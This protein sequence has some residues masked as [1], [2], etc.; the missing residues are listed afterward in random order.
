MSQHNRN[1]KPAHQQSYPTEIPVA[2][3]PACH[4]Y[5]T[6]YSNNQAQGNRAPF[7]YKPKPIHNF[8]VHS[9]QTQYP[10]GKAIVPP[11]E[12]PPTIDSAHVSKPLQTIPSVVPLSSVPPKV[13]TIPS[14]PNLTSTQSVSHSASTRG[15]ASL[16][17]PTVP[18]HRRRGF[19]MPSREGRHSK[20][21]FKRIQHRT[22]G[23]YPKAPVA[24]MS[25]DEV[26]AALQSQSAPKSDS[27][28]VIQEC[29]PT[30]DTEISQDVSR[31]N[32]KQS[33]T[34]TANLQPS[35]PAVNTA[36]TRDIP[37]GGAI[38]VNSGLAD[39]ISVAK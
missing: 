38:A 24:Q 8:T 13:L 20:N 16:L 35:T 19:L 18:I 22:S 9:I 37:S 31:R 32:A 6:G 29:T 2:D 36:I 27:W 21:N 15:L 11:N 14:N 39:L 1:T 17:R 26:E 3:D 12:F 5:A 23:R 33:H 25:T 34:C 4:L 7:N 10:I 28:I 30:L